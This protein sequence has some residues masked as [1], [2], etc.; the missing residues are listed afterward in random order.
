L[1]AGTALAGTEHFDA[2]GNQVASSGST[3]PFGYQGSL[4]S[5]TDTTTGLVSMGVRWYYPRVSIFTS[6]DPAAGTADPRTP[7]DRMRWL[8]GANDPL[9]L[10]DPT[11]LIHAVDNT[12]ACDAACQSV[13]AVVIAQAAA[14]IAAN[15]QPI[16]AAAPGSQSHGVGKSSLVI[17]GY[18][19]GLHFGN[20]FNAALQVGNTR[21]SVW[22]VLGLSLGANFSSNNNSHWNSPHSW[23][24][25]R[26]DQLRDSSFG[27]FITDHGG[28][29]LADIYD[30]HVQPVLRALPGKE[31]DYR[32]VSL[33]LDTAAMVANGASAVAT[34]GAAVGCGVAGGPVALEA[35][36]ICGVVGYVGTTPLRVAANTVGTVASVST[37][38]ADAKGGVTGTDT[39]RG[40][41]Y[42]GAGWLNPEPLSGTLVDAD[43]VWS[44]LD[45]LQASYRRESRPT[46]RVAS[47]GA[48]MLRAASA[49]LHSGPMA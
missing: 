12:G 20:A 26:L 28:R 19:L 14:S 32:K 45:S 41:L 11:G 40:W 31:S 24:D 4:G 36:V 7:I 17:N 21:T 9:T 18:D 2:W 13:D 23:V 34:Y 5:W 1:A 35:G 22:S 8:Y 30:S 15:N 33:V 27:Q 44:D 43:T 16:A 25:D 38:V 29:A 10:S 39:V 42:T 47:A 3:I 46:Q 6:S 48:T 49:V 37:T